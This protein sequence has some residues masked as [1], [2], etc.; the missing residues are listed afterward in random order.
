MRLY[1]ILVLI[2]LSSCGVFNKT[3][4]EKAFKHVRKAYEHLDKAKQLDPTISTSRVDTIKV[5]IVIQ[6]STVDSVFVPKQGDT[7]IVQNDRVLVKYI[8]LAGDSV[9]IYGECKA[10]TVY[11]DVPVIT[12]TIIKRE[13]YRTAV[14]RILGLSKLEF[15]ILHTFGILLLLFILIVIFYEKIKKIVL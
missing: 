13:S 14:M 15:W 4:Q 3:P 2:S 7:V 12:D 5:P 11:I 8:K 10:D 6:V 9:Y 1:I